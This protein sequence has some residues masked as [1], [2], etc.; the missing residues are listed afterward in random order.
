[1]HLN[2]VVPMLSVADVN[3][4]IAFYR[5]A[6]HFEVHQ[7]YE[8]DGHVQ[9]VR[10]KSG[11]TELMFARCASAQGILFPAKK[12]D[13]VL[14]FHSDDVE[15][16]H[17]SLQAKGYAVGKLRLMLDG[18]KAFDLTDPDGYQLCF[19]QETDEQ[20]TVHEA[21]STRV[22]QRSNRTRLP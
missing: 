19:G 3:R 7:G 22:V 14:Y 13:L 20:P 6:L 1:M 12:E 2:R 4:S 16:L 10:V 18:I 11:I 21:S 8:Q 17:T 15:A 5:D 9:W